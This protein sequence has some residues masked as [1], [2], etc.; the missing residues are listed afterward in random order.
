M[1]SS[2]GS[3]P[4][5]PAGPSPSARWPSAWRL[6]EAAGESRRGARR[7]GARRRTCLTVLDGIGGDGVDEEP[8]LLVAQGAAISLL[9][10]QIWDGRHDDLEEQEEQTSIQPEESPPG[11]QERE[12]S[13]NT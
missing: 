12:C 2:P 4:P 13:S 7:R 9:P 10:D 6:R 8:D 3:G 1:T 5:S 11:G